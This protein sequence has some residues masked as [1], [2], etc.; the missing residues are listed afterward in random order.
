MQQTMQETQESLIV[1]KAG[2]IVTRIPLGPLMT[3]GR[4]QGL[5]V[6]LEDP[7]VSRMHA[8]VQAQNGRYSIIDKGSANGTFLNGLRL[9]AE[10]PAQIQNGAVADIGDFKL[11]FQL[12]AIA[13]MAAS[14]AQTEAKFEAL[15]A[16][17]EASPLLAHL[18]DPRMRIPVWSE[19]NLKLK[20]VDIIEETH[21][22][23]TFRMVGE[24]PILFSF[25]PGQ[26]VTLTLNIE[27]KDVRRSYSISSSPSRPHCLELTIKRVPGGLVSNW[28]CDHVKLGDLLQVRGPSGK[29]SCFNYP[30]RKILFIGAGSGITPVMS[31]LRWIVDT[32][33]DV[34]AFLFV[35]ART[36]KDIIFR[37]ELNWMSSRHSGIRLA[38]TLT[39]RWTGAE[40]WTGLTGRCEPNMLK[41]LVP[42]IHERHAF[43]CGPGPFMDA[44][45]DCM[46]QIEFPLANLHSESFG[47]ARVVK[48]ES[49]QP[50]DVPKKVVVPVV[51]MEPSASAAP[52]SA[53]MPIAASAAVVDT[54][55]AAVE[56]PAGFTVVFSK[57]GKKLSTAGNAF[58]LDLAEA[59]G[60]EIDYACRTGS[61]G[62]C[63]V[64][65]KKGSCAMEETELDPAERKQGWIYACVSRP[66]SDIEVE[67]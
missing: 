60:I 16:P 28:M 22:A 48:G 36:P 10:Q 35:S 24:S 53:A 62:S 38:I 50:R 52:A 63:K 59:N 12:G 8:L 54:P 46:R 29:F 3:I 15:E 13:P 42:D 11:Q 19:G 45:K 39:N 44:M 2:K 49:V 1:Y 67:A 23:K 61:C 6:Q 64:L 32:A 65:C 5:D 4:R 30:T 9:A 57:S 33:A 31:M 25:K 20:I 51:S 21:D 40:A 56:A 14:A 34:D 37:N 43:M 41:L 66:E 58:L 55:A 27:G 7:S 17:P 18:V 47:E 26:F